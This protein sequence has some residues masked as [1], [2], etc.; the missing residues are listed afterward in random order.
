MIDVQDDVNGSMAQ[1]LHSSKYV[2][3]DSQRR[4]YRFYC[5]LTI[6]VK[7][8]MYEYLS[9]REESFVPQ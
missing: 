7:Y 5:F 3:D 4:I 8:S 1:L 6:K 9:T 2:I